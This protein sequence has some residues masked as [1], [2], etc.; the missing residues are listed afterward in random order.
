M[1]AVFGV[2]ALAT[3]LGIPL[4]AQEPSQAEGP[5]HRGRGMGMGPGMGMGGG[6][7]V[8]NVTEVASDHYKV[9]TDSGESYTVFFSVNTRIVKQTG[10]V[11][12]TGQDEQARPRQGE[13]RPQSIPLKPTD[14]K[15]GDPVL[16]LGQIDQSSKSIGALAVI[17]VDAE[18]AKQMREMRA[19]F[20]KTW[21]QGRVTAISGTSVTLES[22]VDNAAH[23]FVADENTSFMK[24]R[25]YST[26]TDIQVGDMM[27]VEGALKGGTFIATQVRNMGTPPPNPRAPRSADGPPPDAGQTPP[28]SASQPN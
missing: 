7:L 18:R 23:S 6:G 28:A 21:L 9:K 3:A 13:M 1:K 19:N 10:P 17:L 26:L 20:G 12:R 22:Q 27:H 24:R 25:E 4:L 16:A 2:I 5:E 11:R 8:G 14:I 15:V